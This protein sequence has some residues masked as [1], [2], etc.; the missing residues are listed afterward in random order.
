MNEEFPV[1]L[2]L[3]DE[4]KLTKLDL[5]FV[6]NTR[7]QTLRGQI[8]AV[9]GCLLWQKNPGNAAHNSKRNYCACKEN[10]SLLLI[11]IADSQRIFLGFEVSCIPSAH[12]L[13]AFLTIELGHII[14]YGELRQPVYLLGYRPFTWTIIFITKGSMAI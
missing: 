13:L 6:E 8:G 5:G 7:L 9:D 12:D 10:F 1:N 4:S 11:A 2:A 14:E 3:T